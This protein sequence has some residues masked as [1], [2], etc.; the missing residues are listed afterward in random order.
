MQTDFQ[1]IIAPGGVADGAIGGVER[2]A[3]RGILRIRVRIRIRVP[4]LATR[5]SAHN[6][7][8]EPKPPVNVGGLEGP[9]DAMYSNVNV[10]GGGT[11]SVS[12]R[13]S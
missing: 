11:T 4:V 5:R 10:G 6:G 7:C 9:G 2:G 3:Y 13:M 12:M 8:N 1:N